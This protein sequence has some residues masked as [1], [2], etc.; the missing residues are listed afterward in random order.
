[1]RADDRSDI[2]DQVHVLPVFLLQDIPEHLRYTGAPDPAYGPFKVLLRRTSALAR[3]TI[4][5]G[6]HDMLPG[7]A[8]GFLERQRRGAAPVWASGDVFDSQDTALG[9]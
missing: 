1:M 4:F 2:R 3:L 7:P 8:F 5:E 9:K 6:G